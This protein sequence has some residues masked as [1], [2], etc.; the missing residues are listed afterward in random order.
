MVERQIQQPSVVITHID[1]PEWL[2]SYTGHGR[3]S[4]RVRPQM[5]FVDND[6][7]NGRPGFICMRISCTDEPFCMQ[8]I[9]KCR[10][11]TD[12]SPSVFLIDNKII[13]YFGFAM[14]YF[15]SVSLLPPVSPFRKGSG[16]AGIFLEGAFYMFCEAI[17]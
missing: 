4:Q 5:V 16:D 17:K 12:N 8:I 9:K 2:V 14:S 11:R 15:M 10:N 3:Q 7:P 13:E 6:A 1:R